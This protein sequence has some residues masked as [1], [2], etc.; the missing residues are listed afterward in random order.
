MGEVKKKLNDLTT[1]LDLKLENEKLLDLDIMKIYINSENK[2]NLNNVKAN[3]IKII[4]SNNEEVSLNNVSCE[5]LLVE[6]KH[7]W[8]PT[9]KLNGKNTINS[10]IVTSSAVLDA[11]KSQFGQVSIEKSSQNKPQ[12][13]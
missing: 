1:D 2:L 9:V 12:Q 13:S 11:S 3:K 10:T 5:K 8:K 6:G 4:N 7:Q